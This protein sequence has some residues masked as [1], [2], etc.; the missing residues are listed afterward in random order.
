MLLTLAL[1]ILLG[2]IFVFFSQEFIRMF[3]KVF[4]IKGA[5]LFLPLFLASW[6]VYTFNY[7]A[8][9]GIYY[10]REML[11]DAESFLVKIMP[12]QLGAQSA[13]LVILFTVIS[14]VPVF[15]IDVISRRKTY[16]AYKY[17]YVT[18]TI[19]WIISIV[20]LIVI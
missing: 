20:L 1:V 18:S 8:L 6:L 15:V 4:A 10:Y 3:K 9:W 2:S 16:K 19:L 12:F 5:K 11:H 7:W 13:A 17:P 14:V